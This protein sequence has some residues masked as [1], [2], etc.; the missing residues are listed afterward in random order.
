MSALLGSLVLVTWLDAVSP[1]GG[2]QHPDEVEVSLR[3]VE[4]AGF[5][6]VDDQDKLGVAQDRDGLGN[7]NGVGVIPRACVLSVTPIRS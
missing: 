6:V 2:W 3:T 1:E 5:L 7:V 4:S